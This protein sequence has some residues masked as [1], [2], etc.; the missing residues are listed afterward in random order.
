MSDRPNI[1]LICVDQ[2]RYDCMSIAGHPAV[3]TP[4]LD[5][6][7][8]TGVRFT[9]AHTAV[10]NCIAARASLF[11]GMGQRSHGRV[12]YNDGV[13]WRYENTLAGEMT[14][15]GYQTFAA[16][17]MHVYP[18]REKMGFEDVILHDG[19]VHYY[20]LDSESDYEQWLLREV[21]PDRGLFD[22][23]LP[24]NSWVARP[25]HLAEYTHPTYWLVSRCVEFLARRDQARPFFMFMSF[26]APHP[27]LVPPQCY[28][29]QYIRQELP[30]PPVGDWVDKFTPPAGQNRWDHS[31]SYARL[32][33]RAMHRAQAGYYGQITQIDHQIGRFLEHCSDHGVLENTVFMFIS[34]H[35]EMLG[36]HN[37]F[38][39]TLPYA[40]SARVPMLLK[41]PERF[42]C[43]A[44]QTPGELVEMRDVMPTLLEV[45]GAPIPETVEGKSLLSLVTGQDVQWRGHLHGEHTAGS[46]SNHYL[47]DGRYKYIWYSQ[48]GIEQL[49]DTQADPQEL[50]DLIDEPRRR[51]DVE[52]L[53]RLLIEELTGREEGYTDG[54]KLI[55]GRKCSP[56][57]SHI[58]PREASAG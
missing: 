47:T 21:G 48:T 33:S 27:P 6:M 20:G 30:A 28:F 25:W 2:M 24:A 45:A 56:V 10:A 38:R 14:G 11:T 8:H 40:G 31:T 49:F 39:K 46:D 58:R 26:V 3:E 42:G 41:L 23:G 17:K 19:M 15:A 50:H 13:P 51:D 54:K 12:G 35:G 7:A 57:L 55:V 52:R 4:F 9:N 29:D 5:H 22:H 36:D 32:D 1:V 44:G 43:P 18:Q 34:D 16:G 37:R 53:R